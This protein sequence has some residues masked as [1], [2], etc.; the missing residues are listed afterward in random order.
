M[1]D[2]G[3]RQILPAAITYA[4]RVAESYN[5]SVAAG[6]DAPGR[7]ELLQKL[8]GNITSLKRAL[9]ALQAAQAEAAGTAEALPQAEAYHASVTPAMETARAHADTLE[10]IVDASLW[11][12]PTYAEMLFM[13]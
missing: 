6:V 2:M 5:A 9:E 11:P 12:L 8:A 4:A 13:R 1:L 10:M 3:N 7:K